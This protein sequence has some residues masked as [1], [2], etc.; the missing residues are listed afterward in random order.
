MF[1]H[2]FTTIFCRLFLPGAIVAIHSHAGKGYIFGAG[3]G[4]QQ[5][6]A[7]A[8]VRG[9]ALAAG[10]DMTGLNTLGGKTS[11]MTRALAPQTGQQGFAVDSPITT[12]PVSGHRSVGA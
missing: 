9:G 8:N 5:V 2:F 3:C 7:G 1:E 12:I 10:C 6:A 4:F 11:S